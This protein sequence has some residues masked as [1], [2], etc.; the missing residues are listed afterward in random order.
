MSDFRKKLDAFHYH[1]ALDRSAMIGEMIDT[2]LIQH[3]V[4]KAEKQFAE[5]L[6][7][8][9]IKL[10]EAYQIIGSICHNKENEHGNKS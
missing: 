6:E 4:S 5:K 8:A 1:E 2:F 7:E 3:P 9:S 10:F